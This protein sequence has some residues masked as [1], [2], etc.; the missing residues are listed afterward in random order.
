MLTTGLFSKFSQTRTRPLKEKMNAAETSL[1]EL[2]TS[3]L[4]DSYLQNKQ[5]TL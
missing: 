5:R 3:C 2:M 1:T 4:A